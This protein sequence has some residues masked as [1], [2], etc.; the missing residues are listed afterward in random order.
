M[1]IQK[2]SETHS[3]FLTNINGGGGVNLLIRISYYLYLMLY[4]PEI[5]RFPTIDIIYT[6]PPYKAPGRFRVSAICECG[7]SFSRLILLIRQYTSTI[8]R[9]IS[10]SQKDPLL[11]LRAPPPNRQPVCNKSSMYTKSIIHVLFINLI[12]FIC[13]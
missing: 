4:P 6:V 2:I 10:P 12:L 5:R 1:I 8:F 13:I 3:L 11:N 9:H 7:F